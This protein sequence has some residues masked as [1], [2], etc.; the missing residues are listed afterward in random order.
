MGTFFKNQRKSKKKKKIDKIKEKKKKNELKLSNKSFSRKNQFIPK[1]KNKP[2]KKFDKVLEEKKKQE[3]I[4]RT[5]EE[6]KKLRAAQVEAKFR[7]AYA[8][9]LVSHNYHLNIAKAKAKK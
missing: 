8:K 2:E 9:V 5:V 7:K 1:F 4:D 3:R 6:L